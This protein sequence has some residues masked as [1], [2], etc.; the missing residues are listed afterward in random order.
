MIGIKDLK[1]YI[2]SDISQKYDEINKKIIKFTKLYFYTMKNHSIQLAQIENKLNEYSIK[3][4]VKLKQLLENQ[5]SI[6][7]ELIKIINNI[8][9]K[10]KNDETIHKNEDYIPLKQK[11]IIMNNNLHIFDLPNYNISK[12]NYTKNNIKEKRNISNNIIKNIT[13]ET[14]RVHMNKSVE[15]K[16]N[17]NKL[18]NKKKIITLNITAQKNGNEY[19][20]T[21]NNSNQKKNKKI[22]DK[23]L[24][25]EKQKETNILKQKMAKSNSTREISYN[26]K[27]YNKNLYLKTNNI[28]NISNISTTNN[29][30]YMNN[31]NYTIDEERNDNIEGISFF[32]ERLNSLNSN[33]L[34]E[35]YGILPHILTKRKKKIK[36]RVKERKTLLTDKE[37]NKNNL[38]QVK[39]AKEIPL[40]Y[41][42]FPIYFFTNSSSIDKNSEFSFNN[43]SNSALCFYNGNSNHII[44]DNRGFKN[45]QSEIFSVPYIN[46][47]KRI[48]PTR[49]TR[50]VLQN[51]YKKLNKYEHKKLKKY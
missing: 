27:I 31:N 14:F 45:I 2:I 20:E 37:I 5:Q 29:N 13:N 17:H 1:Y 30:N 15:D 39:S 46:N 19:N 21:N 10:I 44:R 6:I 8:L 48:T 49:F 3:G 4:E 51:S 34:N 23:F 47:G 11:N 43:R 50:E 12:I 40:N 41:S 16:T 36:Y 18:S 7:K 28:N 42:S 33:N 26:P 24:N 38:F 32:N 25:K 9:I 22:F 35:N